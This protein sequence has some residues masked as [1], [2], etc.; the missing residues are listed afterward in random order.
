MM[1]IKD[2]IAF[3]FEA[4]PRSVFRMIF[5]VRQGLL[6]FKGRF[7]S[8]IYRPSYDSDGNCIQADLFLK[9]RA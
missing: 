1:K 6:N 2:L 4:I 5:A 9:R 7:L 3:V 8:S